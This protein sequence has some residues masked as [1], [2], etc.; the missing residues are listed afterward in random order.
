[1]IEDDKIRFDIDKIPA[2][3]RIRTRSEGDYFTKFGG[4]TKTLGDYLTDKKV[5]KRL[6]DSLILIASGKEVLA[7]TGME[8]SANIAV[9]NNTKEIFTILE[10][11]N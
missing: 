3:A 1:Y 6:R 4:G 10:E 5:P 8:I 9:D 7:I 2:N 11:R